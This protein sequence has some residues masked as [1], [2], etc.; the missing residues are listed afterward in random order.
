M[1]L[2]SHSELDSPLLRV[3]TT[4]HLD[5]HCELDSPQVPTASSLYTVFVNVFRTNV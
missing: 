2:D 4:G 3:P 1:E 5:Y